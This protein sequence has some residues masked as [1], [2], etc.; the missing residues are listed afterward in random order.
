MHAS[1]G[2]EAKELLLAAAKSDGVIYKP[3]TDQTGEWVRIGSHNFSDQGDPAVAAVY[4]EALS[5]LCVLGCA[6]F[7]DGQLYEL[8]GTGWKR[9]EEWVEGQERRRPL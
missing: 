8:T 9:A 1:L 7:K 4:L 2:P 3:K 6:R 5:Q